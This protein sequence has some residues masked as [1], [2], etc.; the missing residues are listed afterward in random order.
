MS[1]NLKDILSNL[2]TEVDQETLLKYLNGQLSEE[3]KH[4]VEKKM[5]ASNFNEDAMEGLQ[6]FKQ[7]EKLT[8]MIEQLDRDLKKKLKGKRRGFRA[9]NIQNQPWIFL[10]IAIVLILVV[11]AY[12]VIYKMLRDG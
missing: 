11:I 6:Q 2:S 10:T 7:T 3:Q 9:L 12:L 1:G 8:S 5:L 4:E